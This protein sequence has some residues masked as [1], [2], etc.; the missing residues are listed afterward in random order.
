MSEEF[1]PMDNLTYCLM[2]ITGEDTDYMKQIYAEMAEH[3]TPDDCPDP[4]CHVCSVRAC[5]HKEP[6]HFH[7]DDCPACYYDWVQNPENQSGLKRPYSS[8]YH[9]GRLL[10]EA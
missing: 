7:H 9:S 3:P 6:L 1:K 5:P 10:D 8:K 2:H 4:E